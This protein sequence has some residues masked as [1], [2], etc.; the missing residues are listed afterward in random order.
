LTFKELFLIEFRFEEEMAAGEILA[1]KNDHFG[2]VAIKKSQM[3]FWLAEAMPP[4]KTPVNLIQRGH[5][6]ARVCQPEDLRRVEMLCVTCW[7]D[8]RC[9]RAIAARAFEFIG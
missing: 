8:L 9:L 1:R 6:P 5:S 2:T 3:S 7:T 4:G